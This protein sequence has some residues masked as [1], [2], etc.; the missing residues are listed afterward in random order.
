MALPDFAFFDGFDHYTDKRDAT[1]DVGTLL[2]REWTSYATGSSPGTF[3]V[4][5]LSGPAAGAAVRISGTNGYFAIRRSVPGNYA[6]HIGGVT[7]KIPTLT[8]NVGNAV[9]VTLY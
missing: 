6:R 8:G 4:T 3:I 2:F 5:P 7:I 9:S 1:L